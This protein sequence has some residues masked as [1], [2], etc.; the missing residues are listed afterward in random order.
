MVQKIILPF[1]GI[2]LAISANPCHDL[3]TRTFAE[4]V[5]I[6][7]IRFNE[8]QLVEETPCQSP[9]QIIYEDAPCDTYRLRNQMVYEEREIVTY[10]PV[11]E[12]EMRMCHYTLA[13]PQTQ[14]VEKEQRCVVIKPVWETVVCDQSYDVLRNVVETGE[15]EERYT[16]SRPV[17]ERQEL[18]QKVQVRRYVTRTVNREVPQVSMEPVTKMRT[19]YVNRGQYVTEQFQKPRMNFSVL[20]WAPGSWGVDPANGKQRY[21]L[22]GLVWVKKPPKMRTV[23]RSVWQPRTEA[24]EV[25]ETTYQRVVTNVTVPTEVGEWVVEEEVRPVCVCV[26]KM[27]TEECVR[28]VPYTTCRQM[29]ERVENKVTIPV[30]QY[31]REEQVRKIPCTYQRMV[32]EQRVQQVPVRVCKMI[33]VR[34]KILVPRCVQTLVPDQKVCSIPRTVILQVPRRGAPKQVAEKADDLKAP[35]ASRD[36]AA[37]NDGPG[38]DAMPRPALHGANRLARQWARNDW[39]S[40][41]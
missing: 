26:C 5:L 6:E 37:L 35:N 8:T 21:E 32:Y 19:T 4:T 15:C 18:E 23:T 29:I 34:K 36:P 1:A 16:I 28:K 10:Q 33:P 24:V 38:L 12:T 40:Q 14:T 22:P 2:L 30:C 31:I 41:V 17:Y 25:P 39:L 27:V 7:P 20:R 13:R 3:A 11:W 9:C